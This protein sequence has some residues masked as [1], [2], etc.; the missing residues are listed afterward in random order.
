M[1]FHPESDHAS[2]SFTGYA[3]VDCRLEKV[4]KVTEVLFDERGA[5][6]RWAVVKTGPLSG[7]R[8]VPLDDTYLD[9]AGRL[10]LSFDRTAVRRA[11]R[12]R[13]DHVLTLEVRRE[14]RDYYGIAA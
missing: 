1:S 12:A 9:E 11:P 2:K 6:P 5:A 3:V 7:E 8:Y 13:H 4:G 10:V 14:L